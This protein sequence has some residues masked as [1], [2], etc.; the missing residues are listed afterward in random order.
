[1]TDIGPGEYR[2]SDYLLQAQKLES[3]DDRFLTLL[4]THVS[5]M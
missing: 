2:G 5:S 1:M 3:L 4:E